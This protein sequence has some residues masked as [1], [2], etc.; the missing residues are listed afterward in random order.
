[1]SSSFYIM[2]KYSVFHYFYGIK[3]Y[4][5][6]KEVIHPVY[7]KPRWLV[8]TWKVIISNIYIIFSLYDVAYWIIFL[9]RLSHQRK[10]TLLSFINVFT[11]LKIF[12]ARTVLGIQQELR[13]IWLFLISVQETNR[14]KGLCQKQPWR[15]NLLC[16]KDCSGEAVVREITALALKSFTAL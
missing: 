5:C 10:T 16:A 9:Y 4:F 15:C 3:M 2:D 14:T 7:F 1:M 8:I 6:P 13:R 11:F 12:S